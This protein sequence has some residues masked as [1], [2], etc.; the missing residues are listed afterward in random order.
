[1]PFNSLVCHS[2]VSECGSQISSCNQKNTLVCPHRANKEA[3]CGYKV[4]LNCPV[5]KHKL[6]NTFSIFDTSKMFQV[7][8]NYSCQHSKCARKCNAKCSREPCTKPCEKTLPCGHECAGICGEMCPK[9]CWHWQCDRVELENS[10]FP[11]GS[12]H[13]STQPR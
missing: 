1:M 11:E 9:L 5:S 8:C 3:Q 2:M 7:K 12:A 4:Q 13:V 6:C 10:A